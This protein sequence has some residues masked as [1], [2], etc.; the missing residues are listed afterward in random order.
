MVSPKSQPGRRKRRPGWLLIGV[1]ELNCLRFQT[2]QN[3]TTPRIFRF[4][5]I[6]KP[7]A[8]FG[9]RLQKLPG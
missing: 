1:G 3:S 7:G 2:H 6:P 9:E 5:M 4:D 8:G